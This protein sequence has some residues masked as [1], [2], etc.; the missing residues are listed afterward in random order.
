MK[1]ER[2]SEQSIA[3]VV[4]AYLEAIGAVDRARVGRAHQSKDSKL[5]P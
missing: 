3:E 4:V 1:R 2:H 5:M